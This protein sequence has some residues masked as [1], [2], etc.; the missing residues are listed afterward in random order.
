MNKELVSKFQSDMSLYENKVLT[1]LLTQHGI[2]P[3]QFVQ[4]MLTEVKKSPK[5]LEAYQQNPSSLFA[6][7]LHCAEIGLS[8]SQEVGEFFFIPFKGF[9]KPIIGYKG[10]CTLILRNQ[11]VK[12]IYA[13]TVHRGDDFEWELGL[14]PKLVHRPKNLVRNSSTLTYVYAIAKLNNGENVFK[15][16]S[17]QEIRSIMATMKQA[18]ELYFDDTKDPMM[19]M[20]KKTA[21]KQLSKLLPKDYYGSTAIAIDDK[22]EGGGYL[23]LDE[24]GKP[25][26]AQQKSITTKKI[27][28]NLYSAINNIAK[29]DVDLH[30]AEETVTTTEDLA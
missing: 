12:V 10:L 8:P 15:V 25:V 21:I 14:E 7:I 4:I 22:V 18:N 23:I 13:E 27:K 16:L 6:S 2:R 29:E 9:I 19:W 11:N 20:P 24:D 5:M 1:E 30:N 26:V 17:V 28:T 3:A